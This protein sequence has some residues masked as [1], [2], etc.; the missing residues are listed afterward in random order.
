MK[1]VCVCVCVRLHAYEEV[2]RAGAKITADA[3]IRRFIRKY[4]RIEYTFCEAFTTEIV[5]IS[6]VNGFQ[7][8]FFFS[9]LSVDFQLNYGFCYGFSLFPR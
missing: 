4:R 2:L 7:V 8:Q 3:S 6:R 9:H 1:F 5:E